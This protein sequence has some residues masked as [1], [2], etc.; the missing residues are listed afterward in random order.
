MKKIYTVIILFA[1]V[2]SLARCG[3]GNNNDSVM[4]NQSSIDDLSDSTVEND[5]EGEAEDISEAEEVQAERDSEEST[6]AEGS[7][8]GSNIL[9][10]YFSRVGN[11]EWEDG[12]DA[13]T[14]ASINVENGEFV[15]NAEYLAKVAAEAT[16][17]DLFLIETVE[18]YPSDYRE[19]TDQAKVE[20]NDNARPALASYVEN[21]DSYDTIIL[22]YPNWWGTL[23][24]PLFTFLEEYN[25][26]GKTILPLCTHGGSRM[27]SSE[28]DITS[29]CPNAT[30]L[31]GLAVSGS[32]AT[33]AG[34]EVES[35]IN[36]SD[37]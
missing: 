23:P 27:G 11:T 37:I 28:K 2:F 10:A 14:S 12:V 4:V 8:Q 30:L 7:G 34:S 18:S 16:G 19:T 9:V 35:W 13:V 17:G 15:G 25:F 26:S 29:L 20:Q 36:N 21:M 33:S 22:I 3:S 5:S 1:M 24:Q 6:E 32:G 31:E